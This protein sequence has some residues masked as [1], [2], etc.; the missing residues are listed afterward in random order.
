[1]SAH[2]SYLVFATSYLNFNRRNKFQ[3]LVPENIHH[4]GALH[5]HFFVTIFGRLGEEGSY[6][7]ITP[8][9]RSSSEYAEVGRGSSGNL[10][11]QF[12]AYPE[13]ILSVL[14]VRH[15]C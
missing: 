11:G 14:S 13:P 12:L 10:S 7:G 6:R 9:H 1:M 4:L 5:D 3:D 15:A 8:T 2:D